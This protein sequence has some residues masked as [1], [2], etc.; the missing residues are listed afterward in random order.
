MKIKAL[1]G[2][3]NATVIQMLN[4]SKLVILLKNT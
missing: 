4:S 2:Y 3:C 1:E